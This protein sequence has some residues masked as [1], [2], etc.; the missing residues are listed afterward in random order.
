MSSLHQVLLKTDEYRVGGGRRSRGRTG[1]RWEKHVLLGLGYTS[2][3]CVIRYVIALNFPSHKKLHPACNVGI[4]G[5][6][7]TSCICTGVRRQ[8]RTPGTALRPMRR[9]YADPPVESTRPRER[10]C[11][12][13]R[14]RSSR[15]TFR[16]CRAVEY[17]LLK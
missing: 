13:G 2:S 6:A 17:F 8:G 11:A 3:F 7:Q 1:A 16:F 4:K 5:N 9:P 12:H 10:R 15:R 14:R